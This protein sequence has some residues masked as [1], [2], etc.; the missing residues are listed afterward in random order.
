MIFNIL[1]LMV[2]LVLPAAARADIDLPVENGVVTSGVGWR[3]DPFGSGKRAFHRGIDIAV[4]VGTLVRATRKGR[5]VSAGARRGY[6]ATVIVEHDNGDRTLFGHNSMVKV[7]SGD[8]V[9]SGT[10]IA[11]SGNTGRSTGPHV[12]FEQILRGSP[13]VEEAATMAIK[14]EIAQISDQRYLLEQKMDESLNSILKSIRSG[15]S[16]QGG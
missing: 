4:P 2:L 8:L 5:V 14:P 6:G 9:D 3:V 12:H 1:T 15:V 13:A 16:G 10:V 11:L 7:Q